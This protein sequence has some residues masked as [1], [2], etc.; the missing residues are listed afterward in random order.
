MTPAPT[1]TPEPAAATR[2]LTK[3]YDGV[4]ALDGVDLT[5]ARGEV[6][7]L[8]GP[9]GAGKT[10]LVEILEGHR[11]RSGGSC[12]VLGEDPDTGG[13]V[14]R[15]RLGVVP[16]QAGFE[17]QLTV[18]ETV[19]QFAGYYFAPRPVD[20][21]ID[22]VGLGAK[23]SA[24][25]AA[26]SGG[27]MRRLDLGLALVG[28]PELIF[29]DEP[30]TG[31]DPEARTRTWQLIRDLRRLGR[32]ILL[33]T[34]DL[35]EAQALSDRVVVL[36]G[37]RV[38]ARGAPDALIGDRTPEAVIR[39][40]V[41]HLRGRRLPAQLHRSADVGPTD[42]VLRSSDTA[43][44]LHRLTTWALDA[45]VGLQGLTVEP[46]TLED[47]YLEVL[48]AHDH[49]PGEMRPLTTDETSEAASA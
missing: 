19:A 40:P 18:Q 39:F 16:Q 47:L 33:T 44:T 1:E 38:V 28:N 37:G 46:P 15:N 35:A 4:T 11:R 24:R 13:S 31:F 22:L 8:L 7:A 34:H 17:V 20:E 49:V 14:L 27:Q 21:V 29:L 10:T 26:L 12:I 5:V 32:T 2:G 45:D 48:G 36:V 6:L 9:N 42:V 30:T 3:H 25:I 43:A 23:R 41:D